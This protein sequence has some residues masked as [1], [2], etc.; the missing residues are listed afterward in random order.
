MARG[1]GDAAEAGVLSGL[2]SKKQ[3]VGRASCVSGFLG[4]VLSGGTGQGSRSGGR[5]GHMETGSQADSLG[6][7]GMGEH[8]GSGCVQR[9][10]SWALTPPASGGCI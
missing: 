7:S 5:R 1:T 4:V 2:G 8:Q 10:G 3:G 9:S 6:S